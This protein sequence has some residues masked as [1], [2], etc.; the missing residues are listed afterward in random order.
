MAE[1]CYL[2][3]EKLVKDKKIS[4]HDF[5]TIQKRLYKSLTDSSS[6]TN[7]ISPQLKKDLAQ[8]ITAELFYKTRRKIAIADKQ[9]AVNKQIKLM[10]DSDNP[11]S[12]LKGFAGAITG[13]GNVG[14]QVGEQINLLA[15]V[16]AARNAV[17]GKLKGFLNKKSYLLNAFI[18]GTKNISIKKELT[19]KLRAFRETLEKDMEL[20]G[21]SKGEI[22]H[23]KGGNR[24]S[25]TGYLR[26]VDYAKGKYTPSELGGF[27][28]FQKMVK[29]NFQFKKYSDGDLKVYL[30]TL[31]DMV[32]ELKSGSVQSSASI[33]YHTRGLKA[34]KQSLFYKVQRGKLEESAAMAENYVDKQFNSYLHKVGNMNYALELHRAAGPEGLVAIDKTLKDITEDLI[35]RGFEKE[36]REISKGKLNSQWENTKLALEGNPRL[37]SSSIGIS[38]SNILSNVTNVQL[39]PLSVMVEY[40]GAIHG[41]RSVAAMAGGSV[42]NMLFTVAQE[43]L[44]PLKAIFISKKGKQALEDMAAESY[45]NIDSFSVGTSSVYDTAFDI[46]AGFNSKRGLTPAESIMSGFSKASSSLQ[47]LFFKSSFSDIVTLKHKTKGFFLGKK[48]FDHVLNG[49]RNKQAEHTLSVF[50][51]DDFDLDFIRKHKTLFPSEIAKLGNHDLRIKLINFYQVMSSTISP[52]VDAGSRFR[53]GGDQN[54]G[55]AINQ[56]F[57]KYLSMAN[58]GHRNIIRANN[59]I[60]KISAPSISRYVT[61][62]GVKSLTG[63]LNHKNI[64]QSSVHGISIAGGFLVAAMIKDLVSGKKVEI[65]KDYITR[66]ILASDLVNPMFSRGA[67]GFLSKYNRS[68]SITDAIQGGITELTTS[69][70]TGGVIEKFL[71]S[72][73]KGG[74]AGFAFE[75][76]KTVPFMNLWYTKVLYRDM[77]GKEFLKLRFNEKGYMLKNFNQT[78]RGF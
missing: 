3:L 42:P 27:T 31:E 48:T 13:V 75:A 57:S 33:F 17:R 62:E 45:L 61:S 32:A 18:N 52:T 25:Y 44:D 56:V 26:L 76:G 74:A 9:R 68:G 35:S 38:A 43:L 39:L 21:M 7:S 77:V 11:A 47:N 64:M 5:V 66:A 37:D 73:R 23:H 8:S 34:N 4:E 40:A 2:N 54:I 72:T 65:T 71:N 15:A 51:F 78:R 59:I 30:S 63:S 28:P 67:F 19:I 70:P 1:I 69:T 60:N 53:F 58:T 41:S 46:K 20:A 6:N 24:F 36:A 22:Y 10:L 12:E 50:G 29:D 16:D 14:G 49:T 55:Y